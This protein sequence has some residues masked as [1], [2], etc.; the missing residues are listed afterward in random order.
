MSHEGVNPNFKLIPKRSLDIEEKLTRLASG[1]KIILSEIITSLESDRSERKAEARKIVQQLLKNNGA[2]KTALRIAITGPPGVGKSTFIDGF[3]S[4]I[5]EQIGKVAV[6]AIDPSSDLSGGSILGDKTRMERIGFHPNA[7]VRPTPAGKMLGGVAPG[8]KETILLC[9][10]AGFDVVFIETVGVGQSEHLVS[11]MADLTLMI[12]QPGSGDDIQGIKR[13][14]MEM[15]DIFVVNKDDGDL[16][17]FAKKT[18]DYLRN[19]LQFVS[20]RLEGYRQPVLKVSSFEHRGFSEVWEVVQIFRKQAI[21][22]DRFF[23]NRQTQD[24]EWL[25]FLIKEGLLQ[26]FQNHPNV[27]ALISHT[28]DGLQKDG[29]SPFFL[30]DQFMAG[31][32]ELFPS[33]GKQ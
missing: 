18:Q 12:M 30:Y 29:E 23:S 31:L 4:H 27:Q 24:R 33:V 7:Y 2:P 5:A 16:R 9:E 17:P 20:P 1:D 28:F 25:Q 15:A 22:Q 21:D 14:V 26:T 3:A 11:K 19:A 8:T 10:A 32:Y 13:G 6:L